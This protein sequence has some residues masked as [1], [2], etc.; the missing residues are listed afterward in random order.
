MQRCLIPVSGKSGF[1][2]VFPGHDR[3]VHARIA[4]HT[5][6]IANIMAF[7]PAQEPLPAKAGIP[8]NDDAD[9]KHACRKRV[10]NRLITA[11]EGFAPSIRLGRKRQVRIAWPQKTYSGR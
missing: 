10:T 9:L 11:A 3:L 8:A 2:L 5:D 7:A 4:R 1:E 6:H